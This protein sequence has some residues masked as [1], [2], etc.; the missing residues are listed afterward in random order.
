MTRSDL[1]ALLAIA[2]AALAAVWFRMDVAEG[3]AADPLQGA[4]LLDTAAYDSDADAMLAAQSPLAP[5]VSYRPPGYPWL[6]ASVRA[7]GGQ[8][9][10]MPAVQAVI[11]GCSTL[12]LAWLGWSLTRR[13]GLAIVA[14]WVFATHPL[15]AY[16]AAERLETTWMIFWVILHLVALDSALRQG[17]RSRWA[18]AGVTLAAAALVRP[19]VLLWLPLLVFG[20]GRR[21]GVGAAL[22]AALG[23]VLLVAPITLKNVLA[24]D[25]PVLIS[26][27]GGVNLWLGNV[28]DPELHGSVSYYRHLP[29]PVAGW[30]WEQ[31]NARARAAGA[32]TL[33]AQSSWFAHEAGNQMLS[34]PVR[35]A[36][37]LALKSLAFTSR[38]ELSNNRD[39]Y[40][41]GSPLVPWHAW[42]HSW[43]LL[44][45]LALLG[46]RTTWRGDD[47]RWRWLF[48]FLGT[49][50][51]SVVLFFVC[52]RHR[53]PVLPA[54]IL[55]ALPA[56]GALADMC[57]TRSLD[58]VALA[59]LAVGVLA[60]GPDWFGHRA[61]Y[62]NYEIDPV[63]AGNV[64]V[65][66]R[67]PAEAEAA[68]RR[69]LERSPDDALAAGNLGYLY[70]MQGRHA[71]AEAWLRQAVEGGGGARPLRNLAQALLFQ[72]RAAEALPLAERATAAEPDDGHG[73]V[74]K[75]RVLGALGRLEEARAA[76]KLALTL[77]G[78]DPAAPAIRAFLEQ[79]EG[80]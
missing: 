43:A 66:A 5:P 17:T 6:L 58:R 34:H 24:G 2:I 46:I 54:L 45:P 37:L 10:S 29:G 14:A 72:D 62:A 47:P 26:A 32:N 67:R 31:L 4:A 75:G 21:R 42:L 80:S 40:R 28:P 9:E 78:D 15:L 8:S 53:A 11:G 73:Q 1:F 33:A 71:E 7:L 60:A 41:P 68:Y 70:L 74:V 52:G 63:G 19:N 16:F 79:L 56:V 76:L 65:R 12:L 3:L 55:F 61:L 77:L 30:Q 51:A 48:A 35:T 27:N 44:L 22:A 38:I 64:F 49:F 59:W 20:A 25:Q 23:C 18:A 50:A 69:A 13:R 39:L 57:R 36:K